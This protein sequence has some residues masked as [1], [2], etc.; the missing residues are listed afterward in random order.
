MN[1]VVVVF[2]VL[3][4]LSA[5]YWGRYRFPVV[6]RGSR[7]DV[8]LGQLNLICNAGQGLVAEN[9]R[10]PLRSA[11]G[12]GPLGDGQPAEYRGDLPGGSRAQLAQPRQLIPWDPEPRSRNLRR[13][14]N[15]PTV[16]KDW[17]GNAHLFA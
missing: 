11:I 4:G 3:L 16:V 17:R 7:L 1:V 6:R 13:S 5:G 15:G 12:T 9:A 2:G 10:D 8:R 14:R